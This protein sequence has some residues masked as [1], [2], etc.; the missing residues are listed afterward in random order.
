M[1]PGTGP[2]RSGAEE[3]PHNEEQPGTLSGVAMDTAIDVPL[4]FAQGMCAN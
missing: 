1:L 2:S 4:A 3:L